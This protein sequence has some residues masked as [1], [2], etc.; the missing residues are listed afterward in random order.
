[1]KI[2]SYYI[3]GGENLNDDSFALGVEDSESFAVFE[4]WK[5]TV[6]NADKGERSFLDLPVNQERRLFI[7][8]F[9]VERPGKRAISYIVGYCIDRQD[10]LQAESV[11]DIHASI[12]ALTWAQIVQAW[13][14][15]EDALDVPTEHH[16]LSVS[17]LPLSLGELNELFYGVGENR[18]EALEHIYQSLAYLPVAD[19]FDR[20][21]IAVNPAQFDPT[22][23]IC[24]SARSYVV[25][26]VRA[27]E[28][29]GAFCAQVKTNP[30]LLLIAAALLLVGVS[31]AIGS[32][33]DSSDK[34]DSPTV[35]P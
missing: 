28:G 8:Y 27:L 10:Y 4:K 9:D 21:T 19:W 20:I 11:A 23:N 15:G 17:T 13:K 18:K 7:N 1:M 14:N 34:S 31:V 16:P 33:R 2:T 32:C 26:P 5:R 3:Y 29:S 6:A 12:N 22:M 30:L 35:I 25:P 24:L